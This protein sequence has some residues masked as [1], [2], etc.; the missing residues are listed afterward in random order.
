[1]DS[2]VCYLTLCDRSYPRNLA[3]SYLE[4]LKIEFS[5]KFGQ[6]VGTVARPYAFVKFG[7]LTFIF[8]K[9]DSFI[10]KVKKQYKDSRSQRGVNRLNDELQDVTRIMT[11]NIQDVLGR[12]EALNRNHVIL[13]T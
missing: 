1:M 10:Q 12:G 2:G 6:E 9:K 3:Y 7:N 8:M 4:E 13:M 11:K 5:E